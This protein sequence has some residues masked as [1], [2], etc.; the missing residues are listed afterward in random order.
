LHRSYRF[1]RGLFVVSLSTSVLPLACGSDDPRS[2]PLR[3]DHGD[4]D[5]PPLPPLVDNPAAYD[6]S[7]FGPIDVAVTVLDANAFA[8]VSA[9]ALDAKAPIRFTAT[10]DGATGSSANATIEQRGSTSRSAIQKSYQIRLAAGAAPWRGSRTIN[11]LKHPFDLTRVRNALSFEY[12]RRIAGF[13]S[14]RSGFVHLTID[15]VDHGLYEWIEEPDETFLA[16]HG[17]DP[18]GALYKAKNFTFEPIDAATAADPAKIAE[19]LASKATPD[20]AKLRRMIA[21]VNDVNQPIDDVLAHHFNRANYVTWLAVNVL[22]AD[23]DSRSQNFILYSPPGFEGWYFLPWD[24]DG[25]WGANEQPG[26]PQRPRWREGIANWWGV[27]LH[28]RFLSEADNVAELGAR[29]DEL[30]ATTI[31]DASTAA[32]VARYHDLV[33]SFISVRPDIDSLPCD[34][35]G[36][37][38]AIPQWEAEYAR[39]ADNA[40]RALREYQDT[41]DRPMPF[42]LYEPAVSAPGSA[43]FS[44]SRSFQLHGRAI[45]YDVE[46]NASETFEPASVITIA[47]GAT[48]PRFTIKGLPSGHHYWRVVARAATADSDGD[49]QVSSNPHLIVDVP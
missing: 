29:I 19:I 31:T 10:N 22:M 6:P 23:F 28:R 21:A 34:Q 18:G 42:W 37:P 45:S 38:G 25:A 13:T 40:T 9:D 33:A 36:T 16:A 14:L 48:E 5:S 12:F 7:D 49:W 11:L 47:A 39:I 46:I 2:H 27:V 20:L 43:T 35:S 3:P 30:A 1:R 41:I 44:W 4:V 24:Y 8:A 17:L 15:G 32:M 26:Q